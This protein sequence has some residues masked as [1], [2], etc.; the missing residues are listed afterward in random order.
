[1]DT[2]V[3]VSFVEDDKIDGTKENV[4]KNLETVVH[5]SE[6]NGLQKLNDKG[7]ENDLNALDY[8]AEMV[9]IDPEMGS[10]DSIVRKNKCENEKKRKSDEIDS[11]TKKDSRNKHSHL[12]NQSKLRNH[13]SRK[14]ESRSYSRERF[15]SK[16]NERPRT[17][18]RRKRYS[19]HRGNDRTGAY[20]SYR[21][22]GRPSRSVSR[23]HRRR[24]KDS[25][26]VE[27]DQKKII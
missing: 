6:K 3:G 9:P 26:Y 27:V 11:E 23:S 13:R 8:E 1:M 25:R 7:A 20:H 16:R 17:I 22:R 18:S 21:D 24:R 10:N 15:Y 5:S 2:T 14:T 19:P 12:R 4:S